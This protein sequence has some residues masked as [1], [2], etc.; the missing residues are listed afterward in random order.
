MYSVT[1][2][3][4]LTFCF[5]FV[6]YIEATAKKI[7]ALES[8]LARLKS[9]IASYALAEMQQNVQGAIL[10]YSGNQRNI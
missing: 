4:S 2:L 9:Q 6:L 1:F 10:T 5:S 8:E 7:S 3:L